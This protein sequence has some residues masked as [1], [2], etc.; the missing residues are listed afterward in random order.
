[1]LVSER[2]QSLWDKAV[3]A[4]PT[5]QPILDGLAFEFNTQTPGVLDWISERGAEFVTR[6]TQEQ[7]EAIVALLEKKMRESHTVDELARLI[8]PCIGLTEPDAKAN[9]R[10]YDNIVATMRKEHPRM[11]IESIRKKA[12]DASQKYAEK[13]HRARAF[14]IAQTESA[15]AYN[16]GA[17]EGIRQ[18]QGE[19]YLG[20]MVKRW[21]TSGDDSV[22]DIC[23]A[24][25]GTEVDM[26][27]DFDFKGKVLFAGQHMLP[28]AHPRCACA[29]EY[30]EVAA[31]RG[32]K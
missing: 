25:E 17:D 30:I 3:E 26:D 13:Q 9:A 23:N 6:C 20:T 24:L 32:R 29:I 15:F 22:C 7:K 21:S 12:L 4:G 16:R 19:G 5:G 1:M 14:T 10:Y 31:P 18:A 2:L 8:R 11:K 27:S 28:P